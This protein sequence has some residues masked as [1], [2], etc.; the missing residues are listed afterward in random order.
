MRSMQEP[1]SAPLEFPVGWCAACGR[2]VLTHLDPGTDDSENRL[3]VHCDAQVDA[4]LRAVEQGDLDS[5]GYALIEN[6]DCGSPNCGGGR[7]GRG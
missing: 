2:H 7:C 4:E 3:C 6:F 5:H 1:S